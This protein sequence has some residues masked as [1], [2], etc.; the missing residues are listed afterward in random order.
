MATL[1][2]VPFYLSG[3]LS[4]SPMATGL[5]MTVGPSIV[6]LTGVPAGRL[7]DRFGPQAVTLVMLGGV[8]LG[9]GL[10]IL[11]PG[12]RRVGGYVAALALL[13]TG[14][15]LFQSANNTA[16]MRTATADR[17][18]VTSALLA[19]ARN[20][21]LV[22]GASAMGALFAFGSQGA[23]AVAPAAGRA[24]VQLTLTAAAALAGLAL[25]AAW[26]GGRQRIAV[27]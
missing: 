7:V 26:W 5:M 24:G 22:T 18:G 27:L 14:Y 2:V 9:S 11:L 13:T 6:A 15:A 4:L 21:G 3:T 20:L 25:A 1:F 23:P 19:L 10:M 17:R 16:V 12:A 8:S